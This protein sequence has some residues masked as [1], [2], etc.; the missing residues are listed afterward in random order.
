MNRICT[1]GYSQIRNCFLLYLQTDLGSARRAKPSSWL[2]LLN[3][4][5]PRPYLKITCSAKARRQQE[6]QK[7]LTRMMVNRRTHRNT[8]VHCGRL[9][10]VLE[11]VDHFTC[12]L[13]GR[14]S[15]EACDG[16]ETFIFKNTNTFK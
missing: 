4:A 12:H 13:T 11:C 16:F 1:E 7:A 2:E 10:S 8:T 3:P 15:F 14:I 6:Y 5:M 9:N